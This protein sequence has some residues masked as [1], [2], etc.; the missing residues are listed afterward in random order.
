MNL[1][2]H[3]HNGSWH[4]S[5]PYCEPVL[6][7]LRTVKAYLGQVRYF[8]ERT[9]IRPE[10]LRREDIFLY[11]EKTARELSVSRSFAAHLVS[12]LKL[13]YTAL[14]PGITNPAGGIP[15]PKKNLQFPDVLSENE[16]GRLLNALSNIKHRFL[17]MMIYSAGLRVSEATGLR[18]KDLDFDRGMIK[19]RQGKGRK[20]RYVMLSGKVA[21]VYREYI[22]QYL[23]RDWLFPG[24][25]PD[26]RLTVRSAQAVFHKARESAGIAKDV[27]I[28]SLRHSFATHLLEQGTDIRYIQELLGHKSSRTTEIY[29]HISPRSIARVRSPIDG[30]LD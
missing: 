19:I 3:C 1:E 6:A 24:A 17:L 25:S 2:I 7:V 13:Y 4:V 22:R 20:D 9:G 27:S 28:H 29:T 8:F 11:L 18:V 26:S 15:L 5:V 12:G 10:S 21:E 23:V 16:V 30:I 14:H